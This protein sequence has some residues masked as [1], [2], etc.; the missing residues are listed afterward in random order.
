L[1]D[2]Q[3]ETSGSCTSDYSSNA[4]SKA[5]VECTQADAATTAST[6]RAGTEAEDVLGVEATVLGLVGSDETL[7]L[8]KDSLLQISLQ[9]SDVCELAFRTL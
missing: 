1:R 7:G 4:A 6:A 3:D 8:I 2:S 9:N 5:H